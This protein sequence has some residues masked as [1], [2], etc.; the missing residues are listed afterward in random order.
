MRKWITALAGMSLAAT[1][2]AHGH[3]AT[4]PDRTSVIWQYAEERLE[5]QNDIWYKIGDFPRVIQSLRFQV[6]LYPTDYEIVTNLGWMLEN[7]EDWASALA[8]YI[9]FRQSNLTDPE[10]Y[11]PEAEYYFRK[12]AYDKVPGLLE[13][14]LKIGQGPTPNSYRILAHSYER[15]NLLADSARIWK[16]YITRQPDDQPA[17]LNLARVEKKL[18]GKK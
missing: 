7:I 12:K 3:Q 18:S 2:A 17:K 10:A 6:A 5:R 9:K 8:L 13:P 11:Y 4:P 14:S 1:V 15:M 16:Q